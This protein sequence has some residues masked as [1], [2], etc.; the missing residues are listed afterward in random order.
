MMNEHDI[1]KR[2]MM[3]NPI[4]I[5]VFDD[6]AM[7]REGVLQ[8]LKRVDGFEIVGEGATATE[9][10]EIALD[11]AP[12]IALLDLCMPGGG[13][14]AA[15]CIAHDC[16]N[17]R[18][19]MLT[20]SECEHDVVSALRAGARGYVLKGSRESEVVAAVHAVVRGNFYFTPNLAARLLI[21]RSKRIE[22]RRRRQ[23][24]VVSLFAK[25]D[26]I[27]LHRGGCLN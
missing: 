1:N 3:P 7:F 18:T 22:S 13:I 20:A 12:D 15:A 21:E 16:P 9:A 14:E 19:V 25:S 8:M 4:R 26:S 10:I 6:H 24:S 11:C 17:V 27:R 23:S 5:A 2:K